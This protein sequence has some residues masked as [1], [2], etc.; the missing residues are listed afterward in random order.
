MSQPHRSRAPAGG[1][2]DDMFGGDGGGGIPDSSSTRGQKRKSR[3]PDRL[4]RGDSTTT[5]QSAT[6]SADA[7][8]DDDFDYLE[9]I[10]D[11]ES[12]D[13]SGIPKEDFNRL[14]EQFDDDDY[15]DLGDEPEVSYSNY[16]TSRS[17]V[18]PGHPTP[19]PQPS[20]SSQRVSTP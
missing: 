4:G 20:A 14:M 13:Y 7:G 5:E 15:G 10:D 6:E 1:N 12:G 8:I 2:F 17:G 11:D 3:A 19:P 18:A 9:D 16:G